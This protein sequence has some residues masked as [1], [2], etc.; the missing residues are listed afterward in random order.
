[1]VVIE[2]GTA[3][4]ITVDASGV[5]E[6]KTA[7]V[8]QHTRKPPVVIISRRKHSLV[9]AR[10][11]RNPTRELRIEH[12]HIVAVR[13]LL[14]LAESQDQRAAIDW[15][16]ANKHEASRTLRVQVVAD[17][18]V[19][20]KELRYACAGWSLVYAGGDGDTDVV[21]AEEGAEDGVVRVPVANVRARVLGLKEG[22]DLLF[23]G[24]DVGVGVHD[25]R[26][27]DGGTA[28]RKV[29]GRH[30]GRVVLG[31]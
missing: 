6:T 26:V 3:L 27:G 19:G 31:C 13:R 23:E 12:V 30:V 15:W 5:G 24:R 16:Y 21:D 28:N 4:S 10:P 9:L 2:P 7:R 8:V 1:M 29:I 25:H 22:A 14:I 20:I 11:L 18:E 17:L